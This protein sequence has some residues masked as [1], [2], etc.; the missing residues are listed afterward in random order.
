MKLSALL[1]ALGHY[2]IRGSAEIPIRGICYHSR[3]AQPGF[4][5]VAVPG[6]KTDGR[7]YVEEAVNKGATAVIFEGEFFENLIARDIVPTQVR[8]LGAR[9]ALA[10]L[11]AA[12]FAHPTE[13]FYL[14]GVT[15]T[16]GKTTLTFLIE[17]IGQAAGLKTGVAGTIN[18][19]FG[20]V[21]LDA[22][23]TTPESLDL[24]RLFSRM[25]HEK[26]TNV[27][28]EVSSHA[29]I[30]RRVENCHFNSCVFTNLSRDHLDFHGTMEEYY[31]S[32]Q[33]LFIHDL[34]LSAKKNRLAIICTEG[35]H[36]R[37]LAEMSESLKIPTV[38]YG[39]KKSND[40]FPVGYRQTLDGFEAELKTARGPIHI[41]SNLPGRFNLLNVMAAVMVG[42][43]S[44]CEIE[45]IE[46]G[47]AALKGVPGRLERIDDPRGR[48]VFVD[49][50]HTPSA[51]KSVLTELKR[52][53]P[54]GRIITV[55][56]CGGDRDRGKRPKMGFESARLSDICFVTSDNPRTEDPEKIIDEILPGV[57]RGGLKSFV[58]KKGYLVEVD[59][60]KAIALALQLAKK[61]DVV[62][63]AGKGHEDYQIIGTKKI[64]FSDHE[65]VRKFLGNAK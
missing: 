30:F 21:R 13:S 29:L 47:I 38:K 34:R 55:F 9:L 24:Q 1:Q 58:K 33:K 53:A 45:S 16:N 60:S 22:A 32:K 27:A 44:G 35:V 36:G 65:V 64:H 20:G 52:L 49:Y 61:G 8:V 42:L 2:E 28:M 17:S 10:N 40:I 54:G 23:Q 4:L 31:R 5:F 59:R 48:F 39:F 11:A 51:L 41:R 50:A 6:L 3:E 62:L 18:Y 46:K 63:V 14:A 15:G 37:R 12:F 57:K 26:I 56:G 25:R 43:H 19:R 7:K